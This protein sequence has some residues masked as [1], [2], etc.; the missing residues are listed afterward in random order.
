MIVCATIVRKDRVLLVRHSCD[1]KPDYGDWI[2]P[3]GRVE[4]SEAIEEALKREMKEELGFNVGIVRK[5]VEHIDP[6]TNDKL[7]NF[8]CTSSTSRI[9]V[10]SELAE[11]KWFNLDKINR[12]ENIHPDLKQFLI[13]GLGSNFLAIENKDQPGCHWSKE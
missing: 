11:A 8:L 5:L 1:R 2:L 10:S 6:Y 9:V 13:N 12:L 7:I 4:A 3:A